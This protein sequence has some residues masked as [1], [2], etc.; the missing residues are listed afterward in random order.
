MSLAELPDD[1]PQSQKLFAQELA[2]GSSLDPDLNPTRPLDDSHQ[3][4][5][6]VAYER[7]GLLVLR[8][9]AI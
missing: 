9:G 4:R 8:L 2:M 6:S 3:R 5:P 7:A 1:F